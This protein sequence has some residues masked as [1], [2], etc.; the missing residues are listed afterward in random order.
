[1]TLTLLNPNTGEVRVGGINRIDTFDLNPDGGAIHA[2]GNVYANWLLD[3]GKQFD[4]IGYG[5]NPHI[6]T[7]IP[8]K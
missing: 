7:Y 1:V 8:G 2:L 6:S 5:N 3:G 4:I